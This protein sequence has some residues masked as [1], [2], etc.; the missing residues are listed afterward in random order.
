MGR[1]LC[2]IKTH[3]TRLA[4]PRLQGPIKLKEFDQ[5]TIDA[6]LVDISPKS[7]RHESL[8]FCELEKNKTNMTIHKIS[9][10]SLN[11]LGRRDD[12]GRVTRAVMGP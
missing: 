5:T 11:G 10:S 12:D 4:S 7:T 8:N 2:R 3:A 1:S 6:K 9:K